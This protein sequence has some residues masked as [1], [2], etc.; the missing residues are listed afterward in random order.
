MRP[1]LATLFESEVFYG[2]DDITL[3]TIDNQT[4]LRQTACWTDER[5]AFQIFFIAGLFSLGLKGRWDGFFP[6]FW[7]RC[8]LPSVC[9][10]APISATVPRDIPNDR[11]SVYGAVSNMGRNCE[12][13]PFHDAGSSPSPNLYGNV[14]TVFIRFSA[15]NMTAAG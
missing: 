8:F 2:V 13:W 11:V 4:F 5:P 15:A 14:L 7:P 1:P 3:R 6:W 9:P 10:L 12:Y